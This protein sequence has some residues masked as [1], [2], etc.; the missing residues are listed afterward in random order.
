MESVSNQQVT[1]EK[2]ITDAQ[3]NYTQ[4]QLAGLEAE[5]AV[6]CDEICEY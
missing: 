2:L 4:E 1:E 3:N 5:L 6:K